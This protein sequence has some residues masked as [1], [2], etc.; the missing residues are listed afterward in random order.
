MLAESSLIAERLWL[1]ITLRLFFLYVPITI[2][3][4]P[5]RLIWNHTAVKF[6]D[7]IPERMRLPLG[8][9]V[10][11]SVLLIGAFAS[12]ESLDNTRDNRAVSLFGLAVM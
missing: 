6:T 7:L 1:A 11:V 4:R 10:V 3:T 9:L 8:A 12:P 5:V 2:L